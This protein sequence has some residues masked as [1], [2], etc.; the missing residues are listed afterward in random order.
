V[1]EERDRVVVG[2]DGSPGSL[3]ALRWALCEARYRAADVDVITCWYP[4]L[5]AE[6]SGYALAYMTPEEMCFGARYALDR[7][8]ASVEA[9]IDQAAAE[10]RAVSGRLLEGAPGPALVTESKGAALVVVGR[11]GHS[12]LT[13]FLLGSVSRHVADHSE[14]PAVVVPEATAPG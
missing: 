1:N 2:V 3:S 13:R 12:G 4:P 10:G 9:E 7:A 5:M 6:M 11:R 8:L 14:C